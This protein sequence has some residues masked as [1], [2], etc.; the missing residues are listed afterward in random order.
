MNISDYPELL[1]DVQPNSRVQFDGH[2]FEVSVSQDSLYLTY[3]GD[4]LKPT[5]EI[6][7]GE[8]TYE[9]VHL[10]EKETNRAVMSRDM[11]IAMIVSKNYFI[12]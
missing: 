5:I 9:Y 2:D 6:D 10:R 11:M 4:T 7:E 3:V 12:G 1:I 8:P